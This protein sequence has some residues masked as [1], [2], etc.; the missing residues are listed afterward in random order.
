MKPHEA[1]L[2][3]RAEVLL[4]D[5]HAEPSD[6]SLREAEERLGQL[7]WLVSELEYMSPRGFELSGELG[8]LIGPYKDRV[9]QSAEQATCTCCA[10]QGIDPESRL[11]HEA[12]PDVVLCRECDGRARVWHAD[13]DVFSE[14]RLVCEIHGSRVLWERWR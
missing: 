12:R 1:D 9:I 3:A 13:F 4:G 14:T 6:V 5:G 11:R 2:L 10:A 7:E 8:A